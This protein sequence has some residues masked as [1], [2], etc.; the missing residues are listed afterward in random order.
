M[1][2]T[3]RSIYITALPWV[4]YR[5]SPFYSEQNHNRDNNYQSQ[6]NREIEFY[7]GGYSISDMCIWY[8]EGDG[9]WWWPPYCKL[10]GANEHN[11]ILLYDYVVLSNLQHSD[12]ARWL[13][14]LSITKQCL[15]LITRWPSVYTFRFGGGD[16][17]PLYQEQ[18]HF[19][20][21][22]KQLLLLLAGKSQTRSIH[23]RLSLTT[24]S[25]ST[26]VPTTRHVKSCA[27]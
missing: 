20:I 17:T 11:S 2:S 1:G 8:S 25:H 3:R 18:Q 12:K 19:L 15:A 4:R 22:N 14:G 13:V 6:E 9:S 10:S 5:A 16:K 21:E 7:F 26:P 24:P 27:I 23:S